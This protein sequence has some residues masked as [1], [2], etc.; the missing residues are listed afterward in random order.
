MKI[1]I[2]LVILVSCVSK[3][4]EENSSNNL[5]TEN[6]L[7][8][9]A[10]THNDIEKFLSLYISKYPLTKVDTQAYVKPC[11]FVMFLELDKDS[12]CLIGKQPFTLEVFPDFAFEKKPKELPKVIGFS[13][14]LDNTVC[15]Y[16]T[17]KLIGEHYYKEFELYDSSQFYI[18]RNK[19]IVNVIVPFN[20]YKLSNEKL[21]FLESTDTIIM[22]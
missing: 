13:K 16:D 14:I 11:Y 8:T 21:L 19:D 18:N 17:K 12:I 9:I 20:K 5:I 10:S 4:K 1:L 15:L 2:L 7:D 22:K 3:N 6:K